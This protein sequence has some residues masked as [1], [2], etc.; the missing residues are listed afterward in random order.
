MIYS[1]EVVVFRDEE[2]QL[3]PRPFLCDVISAAACNL[4]GVRRRDLD[5]VEDNMRR[6]MKKLVD[7]AQEKN[8]T[9]LV[10]GAWGTGVFRQDPFDVACW[11]REALQNADQLE[12]VI[13]AIPDEEKLL[14][15]EEAFDVEEEEGQLSEHEAGRD[16]PAT[17]S[18]ARHGSSHGRDSYDGVTDVKWPSSS[19]GEEDDGDEEKEEEKLEENDTEKEE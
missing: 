8:V 13:F 5:L 10:L 14:D 7:L 9:C 16:D 12:E 15:F 19:E 4:Q 18:T 1:P 6:R 2:G 11:F 17:Q 3:L